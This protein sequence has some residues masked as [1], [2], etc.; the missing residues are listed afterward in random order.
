MMRSCTNVRA[1]KALQRLADDYRAIAA[2]H[3]RKDAGE[4]EQAIAVDAS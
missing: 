1:V 3:R 2:A 4:H